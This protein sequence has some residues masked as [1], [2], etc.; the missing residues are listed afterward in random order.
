MAHESKTIYLLDGS[1]YIHRAY[2]AIG[3]LSNSRGLRTN[4]IFGFT[5]MLLKLFEEKSPEYFAVILDSKGPTFRHEIY[6]DYKAT[7]PPMPEELVGQLPYIKSII[8]GLNIRMIEK[9]GYE[10]DDIIGTLARLA[11]EKGYNVVIISG[12]KDFRQIISRRH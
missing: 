9:S 12:D 8:H 11:E 1:S 7:R 10:A 3:P 2:H 5:K 4:A 6:K